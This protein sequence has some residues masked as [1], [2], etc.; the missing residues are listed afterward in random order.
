MA[1][2]N[3]RAW[4]DA[5]ISEFLSSGVEPVLGQL[6]IRS[7]REVEPSQ[8]DAWFAQ[9][10]ILAAALPGIDGHIFW[11]F[12][13]PR[14]GRRVDV[15]LLINSIIFVIEFKIG[16][17]AF[18]ADAKAQVWDYALDLKNFHESSHALQ[19][20]PILCASEAVHRGQVAPVLDHDQVFRPLLCGKAR[21]GDIISAQLYPTE[22]NGSMD[23]PLWMRGSYKPT[24]TILE[25]ARALYSEHSVEE[26]AR[27]DAGAKNL[28]IT[29]SRIEELANVARASKKKVICFVTGVPGAGK[30]LVG[31]DVA[32]RKRDGGDHAV[33][34]PATDHS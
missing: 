32:N 12:S 7:T 21:L 14:M 24:P 6:L 17:H 15:L 4:Y 19:I 20:V 26:I 1:A 18:T 29:S 34:F 25:A 16:E 22:A 31:L 28:A 8:R 9:Y 13:I 3:S 11:E 23:G 30:T 10:E 2:P 33:F 27:S 5:P